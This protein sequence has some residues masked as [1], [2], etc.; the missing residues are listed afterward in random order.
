MSHY[1]IPVLYMKNDIKLI[2]DKYAV[3][4]LQSNNQSQ[5]VLEF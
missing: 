5:E 4:N 2:L 3:K 1:K